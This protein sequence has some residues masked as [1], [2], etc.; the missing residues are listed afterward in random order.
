MDMNN[1]MSELKDELKL[2]EIVMP[3]SHD[4]TVYK[5]DTD[6]K[7][8]L[9]SSQKT[10]VCHDDNIYGQCIKGSRFF[11]IR[12]KKSGNKVVGYHMAVGQG[13]KGATIEKV[14]DDVDTFLEE[15]SSEFVILRISHTNS[16]TKI[17]KIIAK[18]DVEE[19]LYKHN[20]AQNLSKVEVSDLRSKLICIY[21]KGALKITSSKDGSHPFKKYNSKSKIPVPLNTAGIV[22]CGGFSQNPSIEKVKQGQWKKISEHKKHRKGDHIFVIYWTQTLKKATAMFNA[23]SIE[24]ITK[25]PRTGS[26]V[27]IDDLIQKLSRRRKSLP[28]V[29]MYDFINVTVSEKIVNLNAQRQNWED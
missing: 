22:T 6:L 13:A 4:A 20:P 1:W 17:P 29:I 19:R 3:G 23:G 14:L 11:D 27:K 21:D 2:S 8:T 18:H 25:H 7:I 15:N 9:L 16:N 24:G 12:M 28:N 26:H 5:S 10:T